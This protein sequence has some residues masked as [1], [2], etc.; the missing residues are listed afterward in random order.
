MNEQKTGLTDTEALELLA[1]LI[2]SAQECSSGASI[3]YGTYRLITAAEQ[4]A[5]SWRPKCSDETAAFL[6]ELLVGMARDTDKFATD[7]PAYQAFLAESCRL[8][9]LEVKRRGQEE[10]VPDG[11]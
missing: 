5:N 4:L 7:L 9:A 1:Y 2:T 10:V 6:D 8:L 3:N 11:T